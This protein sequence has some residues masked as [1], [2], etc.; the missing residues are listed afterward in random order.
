MPGTR[1]A[2]AMVAWEIR[3][4]RPIPP[5]Y[6]SYSRRQ[7]ATNF[8][9]HPILR[10]PPEASINS[11]LRKVKCGPC[12]YIEYTRSAILDIRAAATIDN[13]LISGVNFAL[14]IAGYP[15]YEICSLNS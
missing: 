4:D 3:N 14:I 6:Q 9:E 2:A 7:P 10:N 11:I 1:S 15:I 12:W 8:S 13:L 5:G